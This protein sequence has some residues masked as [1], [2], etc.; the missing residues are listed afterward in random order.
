MSE[1]DSDDFE[2]SLGVAPPADEV[3][4]TNAGDDAIM[5]TVAEEPPE[6][7]DNPSLAPEEPEPEP[8]PE[9]EPGP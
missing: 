2:I 5:G 4:G 9:V 7:P 3:T 6:D 1:N 8:P